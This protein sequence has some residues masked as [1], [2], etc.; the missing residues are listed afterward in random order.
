MSESFWFIYM[1]NTIYVYMY[2]RRMMYVYNMYDVCIYMRADSRV[3]FLTTKDISIYFVWKYL[4]V[5]GMLLNL[6]RLFEANM[7]LKTIF[8]QHCHLNS[9]VLNVFFKGICIYVCI[10]RKFKFGGQFYWKLQ[11]EKFKRLS[12]WKLEKGTSST[13]FI[14]TEPMHKRRR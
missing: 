10:Y 8:P 4:P 13:E 6:K 2:I 11:I 14:I 12:K 9:G 3:F 1:I 7:D 5:P